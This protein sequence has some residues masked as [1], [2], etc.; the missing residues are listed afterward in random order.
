MLP[1]FLR[2]NLPDIVA[3]LEAGLKGLQ[4]QARVSGQR[5]LVRVEGDPLP[6][7][8]RLLE[9]LA[10]M[11]AA[12]AAVYGQRWVEIFGFGSQNGIGNGKGKFS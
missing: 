12:I 2:V 1:S 11:L 9:Q 7:P 4:V 6:D 5:L 3:R 10:P 8:D